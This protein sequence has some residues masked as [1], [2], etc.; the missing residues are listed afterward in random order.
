[1][2]KKV[3]YALLHCFRVMC[4]LGLLTGCDIQKGDTDNNGEGADVPLIR[5]EWILYYTQQ[6][7]DSDALLDDQSDSADGIAYEEED[8]VQWSIFTTIQQSGNEVTLLSSIDSIELGRGLVYPNGVIEWMWTVGGFQDTMYGSIDTLNLYGEESTDG[9]IKT[10]H[11]DKI[12]GIGVVMPVDSDVVTAVDPGYLKIKNAG[13]FTPAPKRRESAGQERTDT[14]PGPDG[15]VIKCKCKPWSEIVIKNM[16]NTIN[17][18]DDYGVMYPGSIIQGKCLVE[19]GDFVPVG[20][21]RGN[22]TIYLTNLVKEPEAKY[23]K[24]LTI[25][26]SGVNQAINDLLTENSISGTAAKIV[27]SVNQVYSNEHLMFA[28][29]LDAKY[30]DFGLNTTLNIDRQST[31]NHVIVNFSQVFYEVNFEIPTAHPEE[32]FVYDSLIE[33]AHNDIIPGN[34][35]LVL[36]QVRYGRQVILL[37]SSQLS[38]SDVK[39]S[40]QAAY[41]GKAGTGSAALSSDLTYQKVMEQS[42]IKY[43]ARGGGAAAAA[44]PLKEAQPS[45]LYQKVRDFLAGSADF[46]ASNPGLPVAYTIKYLSDQ[47]RVAM[48]MSALQ[49]EQ[50]D[51]AV[52]PQLHD[53]RFESRDT[54]YRLEVWVDGIKIWDK[55]CK[56]GGLRTYQIGLNNYIKD[57]NDHTLE[58]KLTNGDCGMCMADFRIYKDGL[59]VW[60]YDYNSKY[61]TPC[62]HKCTNR[63]FRINNSAG[64]S[65]IWV[66]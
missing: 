56:R 18:S 32:V 51:C 65:I 12:D 43:F 13:K 64:G 4:I 14:Y 1:M 40:L 31:E 21:E 8:S 2:E 23:T 24:I 61:C 60:H 29:G 35:P 62:G 33:D 30:N 47:T 3:K 49:Y 10:W 53:W 39:A 5:G 26:P 15:A 45:E 27:F 41:S 52:V 37:I 22:G 57:F 46:S 16:D 25:T 63:R 34:P 58:Y 11:A 17:L 6:S 55:K 28:L 48:N 54:N 19:D 59:E 38:A 7:D 50:V 9:D 66:Q 42:T 36:S 20:I 44:Q